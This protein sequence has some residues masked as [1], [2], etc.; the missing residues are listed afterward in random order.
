MFDQLQS[1][2]SNGQFPLDSLH[3]LL[4]K[5]IPCDAASVLFGLIKQGHF[6]LDEYNTM[7]A[8]TC[9]QGYEVRDR[10]RKVKPRSEKLPGKALSVSLHIRLMPY[11]IWRLLGE[12][13][14]KIDNELPDLL[15]IL[16][17]F[18]DFVHADKVTLADLR[19]FKD[20]VVD[21]FEKRKSCSTKFAFVRLTPK[22]HFLEH[23]PS[24]VRRF[25]PLNGYWTA[26]CES[27]HREFVNFAESAKN[28]INLPKTLAEKHQKLLVSR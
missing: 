18:N 5:V 28:F 6:T 1:F 11:V 10:P 2:K 9:L 12:P 3:D 19:N 27:K 26:R 8:K 17:T 15:G 4:E 25:G 7:M 22:Y 14:E 20:L 23:Y 21:F 13:E 16:H 24:E